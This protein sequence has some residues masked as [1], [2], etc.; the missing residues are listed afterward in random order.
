M[1]SLELNVWSEHARAF[2]RWLYNSIAPKEVS[3]LVTAIAALHALSASPELRHQVKQLAEQF[4]ISPRG[5][6]QLEAELDRLDSPFGD[7]VVAADRVARLFGVP[8]RFASSAQML[9]FESSAQPT[10]EVMAARL[11]TW[12]ERYPKFDPKAAS[13]LLEL[14]AAEDGMAIE[15][16]AE[17][18]VNRQ[19][20]GD[21]GVENDDTQVKGQDGELDKRWW[22]I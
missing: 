11:E 19:D 21:R 5:W 14:R 3:A 13:R 10:A 12:R 20:S 9:N 1:T 7:I 15:P 4:E 2:R 8:V 16:I 6:L 17:R 18:K 22:R